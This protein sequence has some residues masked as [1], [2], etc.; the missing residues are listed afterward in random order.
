LFLFVLRFSSLKINDSSTV[1][2]VVIAETFKVY[3]S[4]MEGFLKDAFFSFVIRDLIEAG[5]MRKID[6]QDVIDSIN[7]TKE[8]FVQLNSFIRWIERV[9]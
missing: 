6:F 7:D 4:L 8:G 5:Q 1:R 2:R 3:D 9:M